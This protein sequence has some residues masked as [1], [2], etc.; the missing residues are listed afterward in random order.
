MKF[1]FGF[2]HGTASSLQTASQQSR[3]RERQLAATWPCQHHDLY[4]LIENLIGCLPASVHALGL[5]WTVSTAVGLVSFLLAACC[6]Q[7]HIKDIAWRALIGGRHNAVDV[8]FF[9]YPS[10]AGLH[11]GESARAVF[12]CV[13]ALGLRT[14]AG[15]ATIDMQQ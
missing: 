9:V 10:S 12:L 13:N 5:Q 1:G 4:C 15:A 7:A 2:G 11:S 3:R 14:L 8:H 6:C